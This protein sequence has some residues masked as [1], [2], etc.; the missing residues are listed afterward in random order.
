[1]G[2]GGWG[3]DRWIKWVDQ[4]GGLDGWIEQLD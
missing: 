3:L 4:K 1:M 2:F